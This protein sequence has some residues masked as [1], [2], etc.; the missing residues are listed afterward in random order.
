LVFS[1]WQATQTEKTGEVNPQPT[2]NTSDQVLLL[3]WIK[4][5]QTLGKRRKLEREQR[6]A[7]E[8]AGVTFYL[9]FPPG[10]ELEMSWQANFLLAR[11]WIVEH[12]P[13]RNPSFR[14]AETQQLGEW[15][16]IQR[17]YYVNGLLEP[18]KVEQ[19]RNIGFCFDSKL[20]PNKN[21]MDAS[22]KLV[23]QL[24]A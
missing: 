21:V 1:L 2:G 7:L 24:I 17:K 15:F 3:K 6:L 10:S 8:S 13:Y 23:N 11:V 14:A 12:G 5:Q 16:R 19:L 18:T 20:I 22:I 9:C 4:A